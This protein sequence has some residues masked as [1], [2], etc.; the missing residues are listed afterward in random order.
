MTY[1]FNSKPMNH[2]QIN[3]LAKEFEL[4]QEYLHLGMN[5]KA[6]IHKLKILNYCAEKN[7]NNP[8][9][10]EDKA[11][12]DINWTAPNS[13]AST[14][15]KE[16]VAKMTSLLEPGRENHLALSICL[17]CDSPLE[18]KHPSAKFCSNS[19]KQKYHRTYV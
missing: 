7:I 10:F 2:I 14:L 18:G 17:N 8:F 3:Y 9:V 19:C 11:N 15:R 1:H 6:N 12:P 13:N 4:H 16:K 5:G